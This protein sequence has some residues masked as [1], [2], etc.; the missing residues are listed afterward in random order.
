MLLL[1]HASCALRQENIFFQVLQSEKKA[2]YSHKHEEWRTQV[3]NPSGEPKRQWM[4]NGLFFVCLLMA[5]GL[6]V[7]SVTAAQ[8][9]KF[10][11]HILLVSSRPA[12]FDTDEKLAADQLERVIY[13]RHD[14]EF[15]QKILSDFAIVPPKEG[16][17]FFFKVEQGVVTAPLDGD[18]GRP[19]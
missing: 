8:I 3:E 2:L 17:L 6:L 11:P 9:S 13:V 15:G 5:A 10:Q 18:L 14:H 19:T 1:G 16:S 7:A 4:A 12:T